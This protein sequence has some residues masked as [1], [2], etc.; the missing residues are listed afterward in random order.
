MIRILTNAWDA[1]KCYR[2]THRIVTNGIFDFVCRGGRWG[3]SCWNRYEPFKSRKKP[4]S[5]GFPFFFWGMSM[6]IIKLAVLLHCSLRSQFI[7]PAMFTFIH[8]LPIHLRSSRTHI[9]T[10]TFK[11]SI[12]IEKCDKHT[13]GRM[14]VCVYVYA[15]IEHVDEVNMR[16]TRWT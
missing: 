8:W 9:E 2:N 15:Q 14:C 11:L 6:V 16:W 5:S 3:W 1:W 4:H 13:T 10:K 7:Q 12:K